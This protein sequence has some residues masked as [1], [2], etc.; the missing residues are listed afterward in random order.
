MRKLSVVIPIKD[1]RE[2][3]PALHQHLKESLRDERTYQIVDSLAQDLAFALRQLRAAP[4]FSMV[5]S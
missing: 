2:N 4:R 3:L 5:C 1:E